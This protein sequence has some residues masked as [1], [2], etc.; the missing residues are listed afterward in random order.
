MIDLGTRHEHGLAEWD[1]T[2]ERFVKRHDLPLDHPL[3]PSGHPFARLDNQ[4]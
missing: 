2:A 1:E 3:H 4:W